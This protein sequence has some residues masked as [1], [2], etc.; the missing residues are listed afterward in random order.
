MSEGANWRQAERTASRNTGAAGLVTA[1]RPTAKSDTIPLVPNQYIQTMQRR[2]V[3][4]AIRGECPSCAREPTDMS[5]PPYQLRLCVRDSGRRSVTLTIGSAFK[6]LCGIRK[7]SHLALCRDIGKMC[8]TSRDSPIS[9]CHAARE[10]SRGDVC[11]F[12]IRRRA[13]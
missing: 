9:L 4:A 13:N 1:S 8:R 10:A 3:R 11:E 6:L 2:L 7:L 5:S 12:A